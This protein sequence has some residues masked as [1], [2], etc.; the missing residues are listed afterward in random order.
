[1]VAAGA[2]RYHIVQVIYRLDLRDM[3]LVVLDIV[4]LIVFNTPVV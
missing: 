4:N 1:M 2:A 3:L